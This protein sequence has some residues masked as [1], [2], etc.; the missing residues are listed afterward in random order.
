MNAQNQ[1]GFVLFEFVLCCLVDFWGFTEIV[2]AG[3][4]LNGKMLSITAVK[5]MLT[6]VQHNVGQKLA[7]SE[8]FLGTRVHKAAFAVLAQKLKVR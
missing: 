7:L 5:Q 1:L 6:F 4:L 8:I 2:P 3:R